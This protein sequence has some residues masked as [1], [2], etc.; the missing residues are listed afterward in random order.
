[1]TALRLAVAIVTNGPI[2][3]WQSAVIAALQRVPGVSIVRWDRQPPGPSVGSTSPSASS[4]R[5][6]TVVTI[7]D[8]LV[9][10]RDSP[11]IEVDLALDLRS[12]QVSD[13]IDHATEAWHFAYGDGVSRDPGRTAQ[14]DYIR[15][16]PTRVSLV[17][18]P[19]G[20]ILRDGLLTWQ[21]GQQLERL[22]MD[23]AGWPAG[24]A[25]RRLDDSSAA[26]DG[27]LD[28]PATG[29]DQAG[30]G[31][32]SA[33]PLEVPMPLLRLAS[34]GRRLANMPKAVLEHD[35]WNVGVI[36]APIEAVYRER[37]TQPIEWFPLRP[38]RFAA[39]PFGVYA[40]GILHVFFEDYDQREGRGTIAYVGIGDDGTRTD[41]EIVLDVGVHASYPYLI[42]DHGVI[43]MLPE[44]SAARE[45]VLYEATAWP[46]GW[47]RAATLLADFPAVDASVLR[48]GDR[49]WMFAT[50]ADLGPNHS[51]FIWHAPALTGPWTPHEADPVKTDARSSRPGG[52]PFLV[53]GILYR[54]SQDCVS[55]YGVRL[56]VNRVDTLTPRAFEET[57]VAAFAPPP[58][59]PQPDGFHTMS[60]AGRFT[61]VDGKRRHLVNG[62]LQ[63]TIRGRVEPLARRIMG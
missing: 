18:E 41:P 45:L 58:G 57:T 43:F 27:R 30:R 52:T 1:M 55:G 49:W 35:D 50:S 51:L 63:R 21:R 40:D 7:P 10:V 46:R 4:A 26:P 6:M 2:L 23:P 9:A 24:E 20:R 16:R 5:S 48:I 60:A 14:L 13:P 38:G 34:V 61:L 28:G 19:G 33:P 56:V 44:T 32:A 47:R 37:V 54:P 42:E 62:A 59:S 11:A 17:A 36:R 15:D 8:V 53:D 3:T 12:G 22:L 39:D 29:P 25:I 31:V